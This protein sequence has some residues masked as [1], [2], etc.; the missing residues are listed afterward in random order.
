MRFPPSRFS[1][2]GLDPA[3]I[4]SMITAVGSIVS[5]ATQTIGGIE[6]AKVKQAGE[7]RTA[8]AA[9]ET[10]RLATERAAADRAAAERS[11]RRASAG[12][13][14]Q[15]G[16]TSVVPYVAGGVVAVVAIVGGIYLYRSRSRR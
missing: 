16:S 7:E 8:Q 12:G 11:S 6:M 10:E 3:A 5:T 2:A 4:S 1:Y 15:G 9:L 14:Q 13:R